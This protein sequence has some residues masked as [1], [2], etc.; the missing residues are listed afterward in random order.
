MKSPAIFIYISFSFLLIE[1]AHA[2]PISMIPQWNALSDQI[3]GAVYEIEINGSDIYVGGSFENADGIPEA[4]YLARVDG[5][6]WHAV[7]PG[8]NGAVRAIAIDGNDVYVGGEFSLPYSNIARWDGNQ[9]HPL[10]AGPLEVVN[11]IVIDSGEVI[12]GC[13]QWNTGFV[14]KWNGSAWQILGTVFNGKVNVLEKNGDE[15]YAAGNFTNVGSNADAD[16]IVADATDV[17]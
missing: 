13:G 15:L 17:K 6:H 4:D 8:L 3:Y 7:G 10:G 9:W 2:N 11:S 5:C 1:I 12:V 16:G 14:S